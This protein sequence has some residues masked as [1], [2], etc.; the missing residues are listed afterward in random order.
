MASFSKQFGPGIIMASSC[1]GG[2]HIIASTQAGAYYGYQLA[3]LIVAVNLLK[4][5][6][7]RFAFD[8]SALNNKSV[9][10]GY[11]DKG[12]G[13]LWLFLLF[14]L[15]A[16]MVNV[17]G[18]TLL[19]AVLLN[20]LIPIEISLNWLNIIVLFSF[21][22]ILFSRQYPRLDSVSKSIMFLLSLI[23]LI[24]LLI[25][26]TRS[27]GNSIP[28][29]FIAPSAWQL[30]AI[31]F[32]I[33]LM[34]WMPAPMELSVA[35]SLWVVE[36]NRLDPNYRQKRLLDFNSGYL[37]TMILAL[38]FMTLGALVQYGKPI[39]T[40]AGG[41]FIRQFVEMYALSIGEWTRWFMALVAFICIYGTT[42]VAVDGYSRCNQQTVILLRQSIKSAKENR[43]FNPTYHDKTLR[44]SMFF[45]TLSAFIVIQFFSS[46]IGKMIP[47]AMTASFVSAPVFAWLN[48][49]LARQDKQQKDWLTYLAWTGIVYLVA[50][51]G[52]YFVYK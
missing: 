1:V 33:A 47:F 2:S 32:L 41:Q 5:P 26:F 31:P 30:S 38:M 45:T 22:A 35:G 51:V 7:F 29:D 43:T 24:A 21:L 8:Y 18:G 14:N 3:L 44:Y 37:V 50:M 10:Q 27:S 23:T 28:A 15:F 20:M 42:I 52:V 25:A 34:G 40:L 49:S 9:L 19:S 46:A 39:P 48:F 16:T 12:N 36:K 4:Y 11:A 13:Y 6:F 17:A